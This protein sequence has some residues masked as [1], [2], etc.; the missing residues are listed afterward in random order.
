M[1]DI[2]PVAELGRLYLVALLGPEG[3][4][5]AIVCHSN[6]CFPAAYLIRFDSSVS[7]TH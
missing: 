1:T 2:W 4:D 3:G 7:L 5:T 6:N